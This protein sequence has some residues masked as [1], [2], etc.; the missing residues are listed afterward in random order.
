MTSMYSTRDAY[1]IYTYYLALKS[2][3]TQPSYDYFKYNG[4][5]RA[6]VNSFETKKDKFFYYKLSKR[7]EAKELI[8][9]N[10]VK[11][12]QTWI[13][14]ICDTEKCQEIYSSWVRIKESLS[15]SF[16]NDL[17][18]FEDDF[19][20]NILVKD[21]QHPTLIKLYNRGIIH[22]ETLIIVDDLTQCFTYWDKK[23]TDKIVYPDINMKCKKYRPFLDYDRK[24][25]R[26][27][28][29]DKF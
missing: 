24:K 2:H 14:D 20:S 4:K 7:P 25:M 15:Y 19:D 3:F 26:K 22:I 5:V 12:P 8:L 28:L 9:S 18:E 13:G 10:L 1:G 11:N 27:I 29:L 23:I 6:S 16:K 17:S 21:G